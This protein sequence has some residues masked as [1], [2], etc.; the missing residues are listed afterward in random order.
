MCGIKDNYCFFFFLIYGSKIPH[1]K[2]P[3]ALV[4]PVTI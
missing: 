1:A 3:F 2:I 4:D